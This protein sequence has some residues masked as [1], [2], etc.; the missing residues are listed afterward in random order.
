VLGVS[1]ITATCLGDTV[2]KCKEG[3]NLPIRVDLNNIWSCIFLI[4]RRKDPHTET[5]AD[6][7]VVIKDQKR[8]LRG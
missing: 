2:A 1:Y 3:L 5:A 7:N 6:I 4:L 8:E